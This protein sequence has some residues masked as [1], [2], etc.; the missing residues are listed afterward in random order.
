M[1][2][3][4]VLGT[5]RHYRRQRRVPSLD[6]SPADRLR[7]IPR[8][9]RG[10]PCNPGDSEGRFPVAATDADR[11]GQHQSR[12]ASGSRREVIEPHLGDV[13]HDSLARGIGEHELARYQDLAPGGGEPGV[14]PR[15][16]EADGLEANAVDPGDIDQGFPLPHV[17][18]V[19]GTNYR[20]LFARQGVAPGPCGRRDD[21]EAEDRSAQ[22]SWEKHNHLAM[23][24]SWLPS[25]TFRAQGPGR[26][27]AGFAHDA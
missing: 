9:I 24:S 1:S 7:W 15:I 16:G 26:M 5:R 19:D 4:R 2:P 21:E 6:M 12:P 8:R 11:V 22:E 23:S 13:D 3:E 27:A 14:H 25:N 18:D 20:F 17:D 10:L